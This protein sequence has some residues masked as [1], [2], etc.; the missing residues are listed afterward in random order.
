MFAGASVLPRKILITSTSAER[1][2][3]GR[4]RRRL[5]RCQDRRSFRCRRIQRDEA[6]GES[7]QNR[8]CLERDHVGNQGLEGKAWGKHRPGV[9]VIKLLSLSLT[10]LLF[11]S[12]RV[13]H[14]Q[15]SSIYR[16]IQLE[17]LVL[18]NSWNVPRPHI[19]LLNITLKA[20]L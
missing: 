5:H 16:L 13:W 8:G 9:N 14:Y 19:L 18:P 6:N 20:I 10:L 15:V 1:I 2:E 4:L 17:H 12:L 11:K 7:F 3:I